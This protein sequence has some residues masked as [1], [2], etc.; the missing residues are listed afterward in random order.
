MKYDAPDE[1][2]YEAEQRRDDE[3]HPGTLH[4]VPFLRVSSSAADLL[5]TLWNLS[6]TSDP[7]L[8]LPC[9]C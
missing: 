5:R 9:L 7:V 2:E 6:G 4:S 3:I 8:V 1:S